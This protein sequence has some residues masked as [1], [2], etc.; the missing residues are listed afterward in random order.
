MES[1]LIQ[2][3][4]QPRP[5]K[6]SSTQK[7]FK[8]QEIEHF[9]QGGNPQINSEELTKEQQDLLQEFREKVNSE[10]VKESQIQN[11][12]NISRAKNNSQ[13]GLG[14]SQLDNENINNDDGIVMSS[15]EEANRIPLNAEDLLIQENKLFKPYKESL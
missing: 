13:T 15:F 3:S 14:I 5:Q 2:A 9:P 4:K 11:N 10:T 8:D 6:P 12:T 1:E 7:Q